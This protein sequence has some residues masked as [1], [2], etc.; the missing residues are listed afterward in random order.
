MPLRI[1]CVK[2]EVASKQLNLIWE[3]LVWLRNEAATSFGS[4]SIHKM[5]CSAQCSLSSYLSLLTWATCAQHYLPVS[6]LQWSCAE[7]GVKLAL[8]KPACASWQWTE[9][10]GL[11]GFVVVVFWVA[12]GAEETCSTCEIPSITALN[13][14]VAS[15]LTVFRLQACIQKY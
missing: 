4:C 13:S 15:D 7:L 12:F 5:S 11:L 6:L 1:P 14:T 9:D 8:E 10:F 3:E 2:A